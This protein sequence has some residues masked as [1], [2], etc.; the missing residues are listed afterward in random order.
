MKW[1][2]KCKAVL[3]I[4]KEGVSKYMAKMSIEMYRGVL[5]TAKKLIVK[6]KNYLNG[7]TE[8]GLI[9]PITFHEE[10][11]EAM[12]KINQNI[13][14]LN[15]IIQTLP[16]NGSREKYLDVLHELKLIDAQLRDIEKAFWKNQTDRT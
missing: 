13:A 14:E 2:N 7:T 12:I 10:I 6:Y 11:I 15:L 4:V 1:Y 8:N 5:P 16:P 9:I 3:R